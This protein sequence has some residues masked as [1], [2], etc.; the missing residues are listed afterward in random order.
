MVVVAW[1]PGGDVVDFDGG[2]AGGFECA[3]GGDV[4]DEGGVEVGDDVVVGGGDGG[5]G[6]V[7]GGG[8]G[9]GGGGGGGRCGD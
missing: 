2:R 1:E 5:E 3:V 7:G 4:E 8:G 6:G 9:E